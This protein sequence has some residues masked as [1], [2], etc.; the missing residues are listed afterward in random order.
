MKALKNRLVMALLHLVLVH[1]MMNRAA[2][3]PAAGIQVDK[4]TPAEEKQL[5][6][7]LRTHHRPAVDFVVDQFRK[8][9][10]V[11]LGETHQV[12]ENCRFVAS[13]VKPLYEAGVRTLLWE[14]TRSEFNDRLAEIVTAPKFDR[15]AVIEIFRKNPWPTWGY[16]EYLAVVREV[17]QLNQN[18]PAGAPRFQLLGIESDNWTQYEIWFG[19]QSRTKRFQQLVSRERHMTD[20]VRHRSLELN[21]KALVHIGAAHTNTR[22]GIRLGKVLRDGYG[23]R[24]KQVLLHQAWPSTDQ[25]AP[26]TGLLERLARQTGGGQPIGFDIRTTPLDRLVDANVVFWRSIADASLGDFAESYVF[27]H[28]LAE[29]HRMTWI[30]GFISPENFESARAIAVRAR[31]VAKDAAGTLEEL[32]RALQEYFDGRVIR[33]E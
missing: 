8:H 14:F 4:I 17:W 27:L 20:V 22:Q 2:A 30:A 7:H 6:E 5:I 12:A 24:V 29:Q 23:R 26:I 13:L 31:W 11:L 25:P 32:D 18:L 21:V 15:D 3:Q 16:P 10:V 9:D 28:P 1:L 19:D 33:R